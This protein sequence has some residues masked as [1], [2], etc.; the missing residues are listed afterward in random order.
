MEIAH[1]LTIEDA[2]YI[3]DNYGKTIEVN[4]GKYVKSSVEV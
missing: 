1:I 3:H 4:D 2:V